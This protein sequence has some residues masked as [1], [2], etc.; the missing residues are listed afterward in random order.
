MNLEDALRKIDEGRLNEEA[1]SGL[2]DWVLDE[3]DALARLA[4]APALL[5]GLPAGGSPREAQP[6]PFLSR[7]RLGALGVVL[8]A[9][10]GGVLTW[11]AL[12]PGA[13]APPASVA[14][15]VTV[16]ESRAEGGF[17]VGQMVPRGRYDLRPEDE[18][19]MVFSSGARVEIKG[20]GAFEI[21][22]ERKMFM[23]EGLLKAR[24][25]GRLGPFQVETPE[26]RVIDLGTEFTVARPRNGSTEV[27]VNEGSVRVE[28]G[29]KDRLLFE[30]EAATVASGEMAAED[31]LKHR[32]DTP[33]DLHEIASAN[34]RASAE[35]STAPPSWMDT[36][37]L[38][39]AKPGD[40]TPAESG[41]FRL[42]GGIVTDGLTYQSGGYTLRTT[43]H[44]IM[45]GSTVGDFECLIQMRDRRDTGTESSYVSFLMRLPDPDHGI[46]TAYAG[47]SFLTESRWEHFFVGDGWFKSGLCIHEGT[48]VPG[49]SREM[50]TPLGIP[51]GKETVLVVLRIDRLKKVTDVWIDPPLGLAEPPANADARWQDV[52]KFDL[53]G[54]RS[55]HYVHEGGY[56]CIFDEFRMGSDWRTVLPLEPAK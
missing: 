50:E 47:L 45:T 29:G 4:A 33:L 18:I 27:Y 49:K 28:A 39:T 12:R 38:A 5:T 48:T 52:P 53:L 8:V 24:V 3:P 54:L 13:A 22:D 41:A 10:L 1:A 46:E 25:D 34:A 44:A 23:H 37:D 17:K 11:Q 7:G 2:R 40:S 9:G 31:F 14:A 56:V 43:P 42:R 32:F 26:G 20:P 19:A 55:G 21:L 36:W 51:L 30:N 15:F 6:R 35:P 16:Y